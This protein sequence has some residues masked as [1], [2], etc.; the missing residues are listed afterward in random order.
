MSSLS[1]THSQ[2]Q[3]KRNLPQKKPPNNDGKKR[4]VDKKTNKN[5][6]LCFDQKEDVAHRCGTLTC[7]AEYC[8]GCFKDYL[9][10]TTGSLVFNEDI[11]F[12]CP[13]RCTLTIVP[14]EMHTETVKQHLFAHIAN[15]STCNQLDAWL[16]KYS[17]LTNM[18]D[19]DERTLMH[20]SA[21]RGDTTRMEVLAKHGGS[22]ETHDNFDMSPLALLRD[23]QERDT[24]E[25]VQ[26]TPDEPIFQA[27]QIHDDNLVQQMISERPELLNCRSEA[28]GCPLANYVAM[29]GSE[30]IQ[31]EIFS[32]PH[33]DINSIWNKKTILMHGIPSAP[34]GVLSVILNR[35]DFAKLNYKDEFGCNAMLQAFSMGYPM[36]HDAIELFLSKGIDIEPI[37][38]FRANDVQTMQLLVSHGAD[39]NFRLWD[40]K[41]TVLMQKC[42]NYRIQEIE[43]LLTVPSIDLNIRNS[44]G[45][46]ALDIAVDRSFTQAADM[47][48]AKMG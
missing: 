48:R 29:H 9:E 42:E 17:Y 14:L 33:T 12:K 23:Y 40:S 10:K 15:Y 3:N 6:L 38:L 22:Y 30:A 32:N 39:V 21:F 37:L 46:T 31:M 28:D 20:H 11:Y 36:L 47:I 16:S 19:D 43:Y 24:D 7:Q 1:E 8:N 35:R 25:K 41:N 18:T 4:K 44:E 13:L 34:I 5:C 2:M 45:K 26:Y 27:I